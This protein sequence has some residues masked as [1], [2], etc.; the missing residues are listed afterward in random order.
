[1]Q[2]NAQIRWYSAG[3]YL[4]KAININSRTWYEIFSKL[5]KTSKYLIGMKTL[6]DIDDV[7]ISFLLVLNRFHTFP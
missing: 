1:M 3:I 4:F 6:K 7:L 5:T 2:T